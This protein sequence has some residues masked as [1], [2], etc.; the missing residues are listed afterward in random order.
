MIFPGERSSVFIKSASPI[1][2]LFL[3]ACVNSE[4]VDKPGSK[5]TSFVDLLSNCDVNQCEFA[6]VEGGIS[7]KMLEVGNIKIGDSKIDELFKVYGKANPI[8]EDNYSRKYC[9]KS[10]NGYSVVFETNFYSGHKEISSVDIFS[11]KKYQKQADQCLAV[12]S[13]PHENG[14]GLKIG[15]DKNSILKSNAGFLEKD[16]FFYIKRFYI[17]GDLHV[18]IDVVVELDNKIVDRIYIRKFKELN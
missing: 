16:N 17:D 5:K 10:D 7:E 11:N 6:R 8:I 15:L 1:I 14:S 18:S 3:C 13:I 9:Y 12:S 4:V 2:F